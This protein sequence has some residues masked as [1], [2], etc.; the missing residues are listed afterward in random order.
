MDRPAGRK[1]TVTQQSVGAFQ[2]FLL[3]QT[4]LALFSTA[5]SVSNY[6]LPRHLIPS[7]A[8]L[9]SKMEKQECSIPV[10]KESLFV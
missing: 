3:L 8:A 9:P 4:L 7:P 10:L 1:G 2:L 5:K 6:H